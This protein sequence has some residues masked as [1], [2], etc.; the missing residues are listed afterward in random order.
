MSYS[1]KELKSPHVLSQFRFHPL[2]QLIAAEWESRRKTRERGYIELKNIEQI[3]ACYEEIKA[4]LFIGFALDFP[5]DKRCPEMM[6][7]Y[8][9]QC[10]IAY[11][12]MKD[13]PTRNI[14]LDLIECFLLLWEEDLLK[15]DEDG[16]LI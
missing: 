1:V 14:W 7:T 8:I 5:D 10:C 9:R 13:I 6:E 16:N 15:M 4:L 11:G 2:K 12:F 3:L